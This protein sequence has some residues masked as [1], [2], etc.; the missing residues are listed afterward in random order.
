MQECDLPKTVFTL[1]NGLY[2][3][4]L[5]SFGLTN[6]LAN[7][8]DLMNMVFMEYLDKFTVLFINDILV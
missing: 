6:A 5:R 2:E 4:T 3:Y 8:M 7:L 1:R